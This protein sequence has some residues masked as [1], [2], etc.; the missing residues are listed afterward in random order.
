MIEQ[1]NE[2]VRR[3]NRQIGRDLLP[4]ARALIPRVARLPGLD[5]K[6][7]M[8]KSLGNTIPLSATPDE[9]RDAVRRM[10]TDPNHLRASDP[11][12][13][14]GNVV[15]TYLDAFGED[16]TQLEALKAHYRR[17]GLGDTHVKRR[18]DDIL[19]ALLAPIRERRAAMARDPGYVLDV[20]QQGT[21][22]AQRQTQSTLDE[23][24]NAL[25]L[26]RLSG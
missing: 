26:F 20:L 16:L 24:R 15:F 7:K 17:G 14:E 1:T 19:Q 2:I 25:G 3:I 13:V 8:S 22:K 4:E 18:L 21:M 9:I 10:F 6:S 23:L 12:T 11:G 5:G